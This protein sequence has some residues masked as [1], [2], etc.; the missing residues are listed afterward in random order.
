M[1]K[2]YTFLDIEHTLNY[3]KWTGVAYLSGIFPGDSCIKEDTPSKLLLNNLMNDYGKISLN[4]CH[5]QQSQCKM[6]TVISQRMVNANILYDILNIF[7][8]FLS[9]DGKWEMAFVL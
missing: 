5:L 2:Q 9:L 1:F 3:I 6:H 4:T 7:R 8:N